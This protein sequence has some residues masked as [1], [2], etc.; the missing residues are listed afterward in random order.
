M[1]FFNPRR[2][3]DAQY[4][5]SGTYHKLKDDCTVEVESVPL[6]SL[7]DFSQG[8]SADRKDGH[9]RV[10]STSDSSKFIITTGWTLSLLILLLNGIISICWG[11]ALF[12]FSLGV[13]PIYYNLSNLGQEHRDIT[14]T[15][16]AFVAAISTMHISYIVQQIPAHYSHCLLVDGFT[17]GH[18]RWMQGVQQI[19]IFTR[20]PNRKGGGKLTR[21]FTRKQIFWLV[22]YFGI[23]FHTSSLVAILQPGEGLHFVVLE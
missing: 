13:V 6:T 7:N 8:S 5:T 3:S 11:I 22:T 21:F 14:N 4:S 19:S 17:L 16:I 1:T 10:I 18:L 23:A 15:I 9:D 12:I 2:S 20:F